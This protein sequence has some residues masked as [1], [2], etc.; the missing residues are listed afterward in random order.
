MEPDKKEARVPDSELDFDE[1]LTY[2][3]HGELFTGVGFEEMPGG[4]LSEVSYKYG[5]QEGPAVD[6]Y[7]AGGVRGE[8]HFQEN[9]L[10]GK[11]REYT[12]DGALSSESSYEYGILVE[13]RDRNANGDIVTS[14]TIDPE[15]EVYSMLERYRRE[16]GWPTLRPVGRR[17]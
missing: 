3:W 17:T 12:E 5:I 9:V 11:M 15:S 2:T 7:P 6:W 8:S 16:R 4:G 1:E 10:H 14:F 13:R